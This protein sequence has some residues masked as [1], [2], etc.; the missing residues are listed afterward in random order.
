MALAQRVL[1][2]AGTTTV[3]LEADELELRRDELTDR[4]PDTALVEH[5]TAGTFTSTSPHGMTTAC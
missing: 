3:Q 4:H 1:V 5:S 2:R